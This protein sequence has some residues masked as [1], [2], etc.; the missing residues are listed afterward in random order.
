MEDNVIIKLQNIS[1]KL[2]DEVILDDIN[3]LIK[4]KEFMTFLGPSGCGKTT[5]LRIIAGFL[6]ADAGRVIFEG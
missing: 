1:K 3:L 6:E 4:D 5:T 2:D